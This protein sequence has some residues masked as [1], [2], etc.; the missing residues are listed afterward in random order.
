MLDTSFA[1]NVVILSR[2]KRLSLK[3]M[4][5]HGASAATLVARPPGVWDASCL[6]SMRLLLLL[7]EASGMRTVLFAT[8]AVMDLDP[9]VDSLLWKVNRSVQRK[10]VL[11]VARYGLPSARTVKQYD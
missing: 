8:N 2:K 3:R 1:L 4:D 5:L 11:S 10:G 7:W 6:F 9:R